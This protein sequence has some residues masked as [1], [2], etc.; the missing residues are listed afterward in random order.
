MTLRHPA[1]CGQDSGYDAGSSL[2]LRTCAQKASITECMTT[3]Q[4]F[5]RHAENIEA[6]EA[7]CSHIDNPSILFL[8]SAT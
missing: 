3:Q 8:N 6:D 4:K 5:D 7:L 2:T 1:P